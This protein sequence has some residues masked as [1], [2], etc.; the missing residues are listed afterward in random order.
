M[1]TDPKQTFLQ[2]LEQALLLYPDMAKAVK[3][4]V[5]KLSVSLTSRAWLGCSTAPKSISALS[6]LLVN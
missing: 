1:T 4:K 3:S 2:L 6:S 5:L